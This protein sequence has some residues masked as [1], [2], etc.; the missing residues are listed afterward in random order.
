MGKYIKQINGPALGIFQMEPNTHNDIWENYLKCRIS[1]WEHIRDN[2]IVEFTPRELVWNLKY[3]I[4]M[5][6]IHYLR[7]P[8]PLPQPDDIVKLAFYW[9]KYYNTLKGRGTI[10]EFTANY[11]KFVINQK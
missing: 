6:R 9:K 4:I 5:C 2:V 10:F 7:V 1:L 11:K 8:T 3:A